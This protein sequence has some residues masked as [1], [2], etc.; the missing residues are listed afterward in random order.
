MV[1]SATNTGYY[2]YTIRQNPESGRWNVYWK[3]KAMD[4]DF[5]S[6]ADAEEWIDEQMPLNR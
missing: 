4:A 5:A 1:E 2:G 3:E 6:R